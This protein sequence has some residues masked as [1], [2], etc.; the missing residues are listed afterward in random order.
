MSDSESKSEE[1]INPLKKRKLSETNIFNNKDYKKIFVKLDEKLDEK[2]LDE[3]VLDEKIEQVLLVQEQSPGI[4]E[5]LILEK[6]PVIEQVNDKS[7]NNI[8]CDLLNDDDGYYIPYITQLYKNIS[9]KQ[10]F[11]PDDGSEKPERGLVNKISVNDIY[12]IV[13]HWEDN[14]KAYEQLEYGSRVLLEPLG[15]KS[16]YNNK[17]VLW[18]DNL[19]P[20][21]THGHTQ[22]TITVSLL[23]KLENNYWADEIKRKKENKQ[24]TQIKVQRHLIVWRHLN[25]GALIPKDFHIS[26][27]DHEDNVLNL[28]AESRE[29]NESRKICKLKKLYKKT[30]ANGVILCP[31]RFYH[32]CT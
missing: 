30:D 5:E 18:R 4:V 12:T 8:K 9:P 15:L 21:K 32:P 23:N 20:S 28:I 29:W 27:C 7:E 13:K 1:I 26:H 10:N 3:K 16:F 25:K 17:S 11:V 22:S 14:D 24:S 6:L 2:V 19:V 31:H